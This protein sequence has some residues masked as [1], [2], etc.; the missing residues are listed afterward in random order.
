MNK[1]SISKCTDI[2]RHWKSE[3]L[4]FQ[5]PATNPNPLFR[6]EKLYKKLKNPSSLSV[7]AL[8]SQGESLFLSGPKDDV[9]EAIA[10]IKNL[11]EQIVSDQE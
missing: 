8:K 2:F 7:M 3:Q 5:N 1:N 6:F 4:V 10:V 9:E 11:E